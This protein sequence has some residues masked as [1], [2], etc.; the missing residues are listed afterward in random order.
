MFDSSFKG[1]NALRF[2]V[3][4]GRV[5][6]GWD[7]GLASM[8]VGGKRLLRIPPELALRGARFASCHSG[9]QHFDFPSRI[10]QYRRIILA[11]PLGQV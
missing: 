9:E 11:T 3:G 6:K 10:S 5:I 7:E 8:N 1:P 4:Q 2:P